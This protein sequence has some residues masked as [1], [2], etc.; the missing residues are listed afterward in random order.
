MSFFEVYNEKIHDLLVCKGENGQRKQPVRAKSLLLHLF[1]CLWGRVAPVSATVWWGSLDSLLDSILYFCHV[2]ASGWTQVLGL[3]V[4]AL[5]TEPSLKWFFKCVCGGWVC[6]DKRTVLRSPFL[7]PLWIL[8][9]R[10]FVRL[11]DNH[12]TCWAISPDLTN[13][14]FIFISICITAYF[15]GFS[16]EHGFDFLLQKCF[17]VINVW[18][19]QFNYTGIQQYLNIRTNGNLIS[20]NLTYF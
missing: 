14:S 16:G 8:G 6:G 13:L 18:D 4:S 15:C 9:I 7:L 5:T 3:V 11:G 12:F 17:H 2:G 19:L 20:W 1:T 10:L